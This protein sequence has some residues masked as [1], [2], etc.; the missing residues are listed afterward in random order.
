MGELTKDK[1][2]CFYNFDTDADWDGIGNILSPC[3]SDFDLKK[4]KED[5]KPVAKSA[6]IEYDYVCK[7]YRDSYYNFYS[8][9]F[10]E[11]KS[12][13]IRLHFFNRIIANK[14]DVW[15]IGDLYN[16]NYIGYI[17]L[18]PVYPFS[19][20]RTMLDPSLMNIKD[21]TVFTC[22]NEVNLLG[23]RFTVKAFP[24][25]GQDTD[26]TVCAHAAIWTILRYFSQRYHYYQ[27]IHPY[28]I[29]KL[30]KDVSAGRLI[31]S[32]GLTLS[33]ISEIFSNYGMHPDIYLKGHSKDF[34]KILYYYIESGIPIIAGVKNEHAISIFGHC[35]DLDFGAIQEYDHNGF[36][37]FDTADLIK[38]YIINDDNHLPYRYLLKNTTAGDKVSKYSIND[39]DSF[40]A[41][42]YEKIFLSA[43]EIKDIVLS[44]LAHPEYGF[45]KL[46]KTHKDENL[47]LRIFLTS[48]RSYKYFRRHNPIYAGIEKIYIELP[49]P[50]FIWVVELSTVDKYKQQKAIGEII[51]D[52]T[53]NK[54]DRFSFMYIHYPGFLLINDRN[55]VGNDMTRFDT[56]EIELAN[57]SDYGIFISNLRR[58]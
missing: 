1:N 31:P 20:G 23:S 39:I 10:T 57:I 54:Y 46:S 38:G 28:Q 41:P 34:E 15:K 11:Y 53:A 56:S 14:E 27:E 25:M 32:K 33:Q 55:K 29:S 52:S 35:T 16:A 13:C 26:V 18:R 37:Y 4:V 49:M 30:T 2:F 17:V 7:D 9:K 47:V 36:K 58:V 40:V 44:I 5:L 48:S 43:D 42:L 22:D 3:I 6:I 8:K 50:K 24:F 12:K 45:K 19:I 51:F 21:A